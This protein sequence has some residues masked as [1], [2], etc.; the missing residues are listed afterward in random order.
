MVPSGFFVA[1]SL[2][3]IAR[4]SGAPS[5]ESP[6]PL[7]QYHWQD[8]NEDTGIKTG[9]WGAE[10]RSLGSPWIPSIIVCCCECC[11]GSPLPFHRMHTHLV[12][13]CIDGS[14]TCHG[15]HHFLILAWSFLVVRPPMRQDLLLLLGVPLF[16]TTTTAVRTTTTTTTTNMVQRLPLVEY[17]SSSSWDSY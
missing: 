14:Y 17:S 1:S 8:Q 11:F 5:A 13:V 7:S 9:D 12:D 10:R 16:T 6:L 3:A 15:E 4:E 2:A